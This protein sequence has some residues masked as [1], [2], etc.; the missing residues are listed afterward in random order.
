M[1]K[2]CKNRKDLFLLAINT[3]QV[4]RCWASSLGVYYFSSEK[5]DKNSNSFKKIFLDV[6][7]WLG[8]FL[9]NILR[10]SFDILNRDIYS[11]VIFRKLRRYYWIC[12]LRFG[13]YFR[14]TTR[15]TDL[16]WYLVFILLVLIGL[17]MLFTQAL[18]LH[19]ILKAD[20]AFF[21]Q[22]TANLRSYNYW[23]FN[24]AYM[25]DKPLC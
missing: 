12:W 11:F 10:F 3:K 21:S 24:L 9:L 16:I 25:T 19:I 4:S 14:V 17:D 2:K 22:H 5:S 8:E 23:C 1:S 20:Y 18:E 15:F 7:R 13:R 6:L